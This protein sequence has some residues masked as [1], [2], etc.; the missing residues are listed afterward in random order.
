M[1]NYLVDNLPE[2]KT[3]SNKIKIQTSCF[4]VQF[5]AYT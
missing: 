5:C 1:V 4:V 2:N 3:M